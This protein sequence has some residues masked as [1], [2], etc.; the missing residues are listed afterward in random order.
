VTSSARG[1][2]LHGR[3]SVVDLLFEIVTKEFLALMEVS[4]RLPRLPMNVSAKCGR[5]NADCFRS[6]KERRQ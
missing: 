3:V 2:G 5:P 4:G 1:L 6:G